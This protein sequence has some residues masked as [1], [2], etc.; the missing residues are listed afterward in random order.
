MAA[1]QKLYLSAAPAQ[2][3]RLSSPTSACCR[4]CATQVKGYPTLK[5]Y[6]K[7][8]EAKV[9]RGGRDLEALKT[10]IEESSAELLGETTE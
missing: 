7:G 3:P 5:V 6:H 1:H 2:Q 10:F 9:Y 8:G 4:L